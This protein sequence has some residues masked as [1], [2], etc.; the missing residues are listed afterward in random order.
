MYINLHEVK[1]YCDNI[2]VL[3]NILVNYI[4]EPKNINTISYKTLIELK[5][6]KKDFFD[7][8]IIELYDIRLYRVVMKEI[9]NDFIWLKNN[10]ED[11]T[12]DE[13]IN[14]S[15]EDYEK[16]MEKVSY[17]DK[18]GEINEESLYYKTL[19]NSKIIT[20]KTKN[21]FFDLNKLVDSEILEYFVS[22]SL[23][24]LISNGE[25]FNVVVEESLKQISIISK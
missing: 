25:G 5:F 14:I 6:I 2:D 1:K 22:E 8:D 24:M 17:T 11:L 10:V 3:K 4:V 13:L 20:K 19:N 18:I 23:D 16:Y 9:L 7:L 21:Y 12:E 15:E